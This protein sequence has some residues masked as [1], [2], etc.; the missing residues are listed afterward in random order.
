MKYGKRAGVFQ[1]IFGLRLK[2]LG[3]L[4]TQLVRNSEFYTISLE[5]LHS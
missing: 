1:P 4:Q 5:K 3:A 2:V